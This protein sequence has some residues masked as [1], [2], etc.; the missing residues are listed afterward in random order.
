MKMTNIFKTENFLFD[1]E[2]H[3]IRINGKQV[4]MVGTF[5]DPYFCGKD[6]AEALGYK[7][8][9]QTINERID[10]EDK[11]MLNDLEKI[12]CAQDSLVHRNQVFYWPFKTKLNAGK[13]GRFVYLSE[14]G[15]YELTSSSQLPIGKQFKKWL[16]NL[17]KEIY[18]W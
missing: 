3:E 4:K 8:V 5:E 9:Q 6:V 15:V 12:F 17:V 2:N 11:K 13:E 7:G 1:V 18:G 10:K 14:Q 16:Q